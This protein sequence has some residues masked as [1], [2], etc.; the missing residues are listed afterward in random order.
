MVTFPESGAG[1]AEQMDLL[2]ARRPGQRFLLTVHNPGW[3][4]EAAGPLAPLLLLAQDGAAPPARRPVQLLSLAPCGATYSR[5]LAQ[6]W[7]AAMRRWLPGQSP[8]APAP[9]VEVPWIVPLVP[10]EPPASKDAADEEAPADGGGGN[11]TNSTKAARRQREGAAAAAAPPLR[12]LCIQGNLDP[13]RRNYAAAFAAAGHP[14]VVGQLRER[15]ERLLLVGSDQGRK[16]EVPPALKEY[17]EPRLDL[18][19]EV[20]AGQSVPPV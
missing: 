8:A 7:V 1:L 6:S 13:A 16:L 9:E 20:S 15:D 18:D 12:H 5:S 2:L 17:V 11:S 10:W 3:L 14:A 4:L 19:Y